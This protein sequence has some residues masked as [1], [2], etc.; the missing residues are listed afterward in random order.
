MT[1]I[2]DR[3]GVNRGGGQDIFTTQNYTQGTGTGTSTITLTPGND[4]TI[5]GGTAPVEGNTFIIASTAVSPDTTYELTWDSSSEELSL[6]H[7]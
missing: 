1:G 7:I 2:F 6:I 5:N 4:I 3:D